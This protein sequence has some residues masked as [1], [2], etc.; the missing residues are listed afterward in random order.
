MR[1]VSVSREPELKNPATARTSSFSTAQCFSES[2]KLVGDLLDSAHNFFVGNFVAIERVPSRVNK[3]WNDHRSKI[4]HEA[5]GI[6]HYRHVAA[7]AAGCAK[8]SDDFF[9][10]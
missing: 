3:T 10:P 8:K 2:H 7:G 6:G 1:I 4:K 5:V 9:L